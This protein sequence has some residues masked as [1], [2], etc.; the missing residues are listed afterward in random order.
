MNLLMLTPWM[1]VGF[2]LPEV[3]DSLAVRLEDKGISTYVGCIEFDDSFPHL[4][5]DVVD[6]KQA[7]VVEA[8]R[9]LDIDIVVAL[10]S[11][12]FEVL[13]Q[14]QG[15]KTVVFEAGDPTPEMFTADASE[16]RAIVENKERN[17]YPYVDGAAAISEFIRHEIGIPAAVIILGVDHI[18]DLGPKTPDMDGSAG[19]EVRVGTLMRLG[20]G[21]AQYKGNDLL[22]VIRDATLDRGVAAQF[23][24][25]GRGTDEDAQRLRAAGF[26]VHLNASDDERRDFL[27]EIDVFVTPSQWEGCN[28]PLIEAQALGTP[29]LAFDTGAHPEYTPLLYSSVADLVEQLVAYSENPDLLSAHGDLCYRFARS[30]LSWDQAAVDFADFLDLVQRGEWQR[31]PGLFARGRRNAGR[32]KRSIAARGWVGTARLSAA[33]VRAKKK[34]KS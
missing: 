3:I 9:R 16:R 20:A 26:R 1:K 22:P 31:R 27:R 10:G 13:P 11:P 6:P 19:R 21:E 12:Y 8:V 32:V 23:H 17:V 24:V 33:K 18:P 30:E 15:V 14:L 2:G 28:L 5:V 29:G 4:R 25:M 34:P 7:A